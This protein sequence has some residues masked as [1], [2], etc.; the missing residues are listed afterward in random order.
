MLVALPRA[1]MLKK[2]LEALDLRSTPFVQTHFSKRLRSYE[3]RPDG[4]V[5][6]FTNGSIGH[7]DILVGADGIGSATRKQMYND[8]SERTAGTDPDG[9]NALLNF[10]QP[11]WTGTYAYRALLDAQKLKQTAP[12]NIILKSGQMVSISCWSNVLQLIDVSQWCGRDKVRAI[13]M[14]RR[15]RL[16]MATAKA[17]RIV[18]HLPD[19]G[20]R[21]SVRDHSWRPRSTSPRSVRQP[22][23][24]GTRR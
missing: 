9:A 5:L 24:E 7:A 3:Q 13:L 20:Q 12:D 10:R 4:V 14:L 15:C 23:V 11:T 22:R 6:Y 8:L 2:L 16:D 18:P 1:E 21:R 17:R 19:Y